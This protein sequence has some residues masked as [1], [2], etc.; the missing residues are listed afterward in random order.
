LN[1][2]NSLS[3]VILISLIISCGVKSDPSPPSD[4]I[5]PSIE[6]QFMLSPSKITEK[7]EKENKKK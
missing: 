5:L 4:T 7:E 3:F 2:K 6:K 1:F